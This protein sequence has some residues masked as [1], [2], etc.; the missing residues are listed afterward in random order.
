MKS[1]STLTKEE[2]KTRREQINIRQE[3]I[4]KC[5]EKGISCDYG[6]CDECPVMTRKWEKKWIKDILKEN[7]K[8]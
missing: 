8:N 1:L 5:Q 3:E 7:R 6:I 2:R 4:R